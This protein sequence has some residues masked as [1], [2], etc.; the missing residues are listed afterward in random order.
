MIQ[1]LFGIASQLRKWTRPVR[2]S[3]YRAY[4]RTFPCCACGQNWWIE[5]AHTGPH[6]LS[7]KASDTTCIPLC[8]KCHEAY[9]KSPAKFA[10]SHHLDVEALTTMFQHWY[11]VEFPERFRYAA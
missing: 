8:R 11:R 6:A 10:A 1:S 2:D 3:L 7:K 5:A 4:I 9:G